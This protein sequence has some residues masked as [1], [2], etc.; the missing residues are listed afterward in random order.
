MNDPL[1]FE[2]NLPDMPCS[3]TERTSSG[4]TLD[5]ALDA[6]LAEDFAHEDWLHVHSWNDD[7]EMAR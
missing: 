6:W 1:T 7:G 5:E 2:L 3:V 4:R